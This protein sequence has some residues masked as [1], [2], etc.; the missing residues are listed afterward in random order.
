MRIDERQAGVN[1]EVRVATLPDVREWGERMPVEIWLN[2]RGRTVIRAWNEC[3][4]NSTDVDLF[5]LLAWVHG[6]VEGDWKYAIDR[7]TSI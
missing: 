4:K 2:Q 7:V 3:G 1:I 5:D 6:G